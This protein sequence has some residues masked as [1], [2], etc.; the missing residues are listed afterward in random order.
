MQMRGQAI[1]DS[2]G[3]PVFDVKTAIA[4][5]DTLMIA[6]PLSEVLPGM[7]M[8]LAQVRHR[9]SFRIYLTGREKDGVTESLF[10]KAVRELNKQLSKVVADT[11]RFVMKVH[12]R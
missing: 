5:Y 4:V 7:P 1:A 9:A 11:S 12:N 8:M 2:S 10:R 3:L 6:K